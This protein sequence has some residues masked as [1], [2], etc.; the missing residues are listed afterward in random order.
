MDADRNPDHD[1]LI[2]SPVGEY[3]VTKRLGEGGMGIVYAAEHPVIGKRVAVKV[4]RPQTAEIESQVQRFVAE[5][6]TVCAIGHR[7]IVDVFGFGT[8]PDGRHYLL[9]ELLTGEPLDR[10]LSTH[11]PLP[12][13]EAIDLLDEILDALGAAHRVGVIHRD[14]KPS[15]IFYV[16]PPLG[17]PYL[18]LLDFGLAKRSSVPHGSADQTTGMYWVGTPD[19]MAPEQARGEPVGP[20]TDLYSLGIIAFQM[21]TGKVPFRAS[22]AMDIVAL[23]LRQPAPRVS[24]RAAGVPRQLD[25]LVSRLLQKRPE[26]RPASA[27]LVRA[28]LASIRRFL[29]G[30]ATVNNLDPAELRASEPASE[31]AGALRP[32]AM[33][34]VDVPDTV[35]HASD[36][37]GVSAPAPAPPTTRKDE[38][39]APARR[40]IGA[41]AGFLVVAGGTL[42][43]LRWLDKASAAPPLQDFREQTQVSHPLPSSSPS[44]P[45][46]SQKGRLLGQI[47]ALAA[48]VKK[49]TGGAVTVGEL[50]LS[51]IRAD[52]E[53]AATPAEIEKVE[54][55]L[56]SWKREYLR[57]PQRP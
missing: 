35:A 5:A 34:R 27:A 52:A 18:K 43:A 8:M 30:D 57:S 31:A 48:R 56:E 21:L 55:D 15:N 28:E 36:A 46:G 49:R 7:G 50:K 12:A 39:P 40:W 16:R 54:R 44:S 45:S 13:M 4:L 10:Y 24:S 33:E 42:A 20:Y 32:T 51:R 14:L 23:H 53:G 22:T 26:E 2:G 6:R 11:A 19:F 9:M 47:E 37:I 1:L 25:A 17:Q 38:R 3:Y 29:S 41:V